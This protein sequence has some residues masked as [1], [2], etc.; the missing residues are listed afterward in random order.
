MSIAT[1]VTLGYGSFGSVSEVVTL[2]YSI[3]AVSA[4][5]AAPERT[6]PVEYERRA[7]SVPAENRVLGI[8]RENRERPIH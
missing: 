2:G 6:F 4:F 5:I 7:F 8:E 1:I 3:G